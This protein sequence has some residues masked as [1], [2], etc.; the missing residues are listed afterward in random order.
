MRLVFI[1]THFDYLDGSTRFILEICRHLKHLGHAPYGICLNSSHHVL[2]E[3]RDVENSLVSLDEPP[4][5]SLRFWLR[6]PLIRKKIRKKIRELRPDCIIANVF[7][8]QYLIPDLPKIA[9]VWYCHEPSAYIFRSHSIGNLPP[10]QRAFIKAFKVLMASYDKRQVDRVN[11]L[12]CNSHFTA[13]M[14]WRT[15][16]RKADVVYP[17]VDTKR[18]RR[19]TM[20]KAEPK[21]LLCVGPLQKSK[22]LD[23][24]LHAAKVV[25]FHRRDFRLVV[26]GDGPEYRNLSNLADTL[27]ISHLTEFRRYVSEEE[28]IRLYSEA[29]TVVYPSLEE[30]FGLVPL[31]AM[32][33]GTS[34][35]ACKSG[36]PCE[37]IVDGE[38]GFLVD[39]HDFRQLSNRLELLLS[40]SK[41]A[42]D[43]GYASRER[44]VE[45]FSWERAAEELCRVSLSGERFAA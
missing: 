2:S 32:S 4:A 21:I 33:C 35:I 17:G 34:V 13:N 8:A 45:R 42:V 1:H 31:E 24:V 43:L 36:G 38:T 18:F 23:M 30:P 37:T 29:T 9:K 40:D 12:A 10:R 5:R 19:V 41:L 7:P 20:K 27:G 3:Y 6:L 25:S 11:A 28:L 22:R 14:I 16:G 39:P 44:M 15:Y 26:A